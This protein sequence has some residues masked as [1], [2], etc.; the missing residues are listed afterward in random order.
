LQ[1]DFSMALK[2]NGMSPFPPDTPPIAGMTKVADSDAP[3]SSASPTDT[4]ATEFADSSPRSGSPTPL[5]DPMSKVFVQ[6]QLRAEVKTGGG[7]SAATAVKAQLREQRLDELA[8]LPGEAHAAW[9]KL[10]DADRAAVLKK[11]EANYGKAFK[12]QFL[13]TAT[14]GKAQVETSTYSNSPKSNFPM[15]TDEQLKARGYQKAGTEHTGNAAIN[16]EVWVHPSGKTIRRDISTDKF[17]PG[18]SGQAPAG[19]TGANKTTGPEDVDEPGDEE[20]AQDKAVQLLDAAQ[21]GHRN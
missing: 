21:K 19:N 8:R 13:Q 15:I 18:D 10:N 2:I 20:D 1:E 16:I 4:P 11:M 12:D 9:S 7:P 17:G 3:V 6:S 5:D 14:K